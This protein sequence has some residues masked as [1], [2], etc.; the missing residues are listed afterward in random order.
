MKHEELKE[1]LKI[2]QQW[3]F[4]SGNS[5]SYLPI[6]LFNVYCSIEEENSEGSL[7]ELKV[8]LNEV[9][10]VLILSS[11]PRK[12]YT[13][14]LLNFLID[15]F[16][17]RED[18]ILPKEIQ[19]I[20]L[21]NNDSVIQIGRIHSAYGSVQ[22]FIEHYQNIVLEYKPTH[23]IFME[24]VNLDCEIDDPNS[25]KVFSNNELKQMYDLVKEVQDRLGINKVFSPNHF[26]HIPY[27]Q[28]NKKSFLVDLD[29]DV[30]NG[31][32]CSLS[33]TKSY[34]DK[35][36]F[37]LAYSLNRGLNR[38]IKKFSIKLS[39]SHQGKLKLLSETK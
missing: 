34:V 3:M 39:C 6:A 21:W 27:Q 5:W 4:F 29:Y 25:N 36:S 35:A 26:F 22:S 14:N 9:P 10:R 7:K 17:G 1:L 32:V 33:Q 11:N 8:L 16:V 28:L 20:N 2:N 18:Y 15:G 13:S 31:I 19:G 30:K 12:F 37:E 24:S 23:V 38:K